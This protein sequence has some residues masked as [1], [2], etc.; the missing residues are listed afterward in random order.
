MHQKTLS[1][2]DA[3]ADVDVLGAEEGPVAAHRDQLKDGTRREPVHPFPMA[4]SLAELGHGSI[5]PELLTLV[6]LDQQHIDTIVQT[7][8][9]GARNVQDIYPLSPVQEG[10]L[11]HYL[12][13]DR[14]DTYV[15][16]T[17]FELQ[18]EIHVGELITGLQRVI[19]RHDALRSAVLW[20][21]LP[22][23]IQVVYRHADLPVET[24]D[25]DR[26]QDPIEQLKARMDPEQDRMD[27]RRPPLMRLFIAEDRERQVWYA[28]LKRHH[29]V[30]DH[31]S[32]NA[33][34]AEAIACADGR[35]AE[36]PRPG[37]YRNY[38]AWA[39]TGSATQ[40]AE[41]FFRG[42]LGNVTEPT[43]PFGVLSTAGDEEPLEE[44]RI[45]LNPMLTERIRA[46]ARA[47]DVSPARL[48]HAMWA[49]VVARASG[50]DDVVYGTVLSGWSRKNRREEPTIGLF[51]NTL[52][53][54]LTLEGMTV[55]Q[56]IE[57]T[58]IELRDLLPY[59]Q[60]SQT[61]AQSCSGVGGNA[62]LF[63]AVI[64]YRHSAGHS[65]VDTRSNADRFRMIAQG[66]RTDYPVM[67]VVDDFGDGFD[68]TAQAVR[69]IGADRLGAYAVTALQSLVHA[70][71]Q[72]PHS[73][74]RALKVL[75]EDEWHQV[76]RGFN[77]TQ[78]PYRQE[79]LIHQLFEEQV[80]RAP[81]SVALIYENE[82]LSYSE[83]N[84]RANQLARYL[85]ARGVGQDE[86]VGICVERS[87]EMVVGLLGI[88]KAGG[89]YVPLDPDYPQERLAYMVASSAPRVLLTQQRLRERL[90]ATAAEVIELDGQW[91]QIASHDVSNLDTSE[92]GFN[93][94][95]L[96][97]VIYT[98]GSTGQPKGAMN[99]H[100]A[101]INRLQWMQH[102][103][104]LGSADR[105]L[106]KT[107]FSFDVSAWEFFWTLMY[108]ARLIVARPR[109]HQDPQYLRELIEERQVTRLHFVP[110]M[111]QIFLDQL[112][113]GQCPTLRHVVCSGEELP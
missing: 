55:K 23:P 48:F 22:R 93:S 38:V 50:R 34:F 17:L 15:L 51:V 103:Y 110:S 7:V 112:Q 64:N 108:G 20:E 8:P 47:H 85:R 11:F 102:A 52:P 28:L 16:S 18:S 95:Q 43:A 106:Q 54:A 66:Y 70:L 75:P 32:W 1:R 62:P 87:V 104:G 21:S 94:R 13:N 42:K 35:E 63:S 78:A 57:R 61:L 3:G 101:L 83:L 37:S 74:V 29:I 41:D 30:F 58:N 39:L 91:H 49:L 67:L 33:A 72:T 45:T 27:L 12:L 59:Q 6:D 96:A 71:E 90:P 100:R 79:K 92:L 98:S 25:L 65:V 111:L 31:Q 86:L 80:E 113:V 88:L 97:Y 82:S 44:A 68:L 24:I 73:P 105:V 2:M 84:N 9:G 99:E 81:Q 14:S 4:R 89:A 69:R 77:W 5:T 36:L 10:I 19:D 46:Q 107:P 76:V 109:G 56:L 40:R 60:V 26:S 53:V